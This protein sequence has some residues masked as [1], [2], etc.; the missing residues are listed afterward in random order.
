[1]DKI[2]K[3]FHLEREDQNKRHWI[4]KEKLTEM[5]EFDFRQKEM[6]LTREIAALQEELAKSTKL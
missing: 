6:E 3:N 1:M 5:Y 2:I 4:E